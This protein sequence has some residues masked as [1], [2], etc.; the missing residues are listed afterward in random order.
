ML[1]FRIFFLITLAYFAQACGQTGALYLP[2]KPE[3]AKQA[4]PLPSDER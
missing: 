1:S 3:S 2:D 4:K